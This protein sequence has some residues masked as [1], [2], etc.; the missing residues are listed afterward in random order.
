VTR[1]ALVFASAVALNYLW[2]LAQSPLYVGVDFPA[3]WLH[4]F[5]ASL[6]DGLMV[7]T[8]F[9]IVALLAQSMDWYRRPAAWHYAAMAAAALAIAFAVEWWGLHV[10]K[11][12]QYS[13]LMPLIPGTGMGAVP[14]AQ[15]LALPPLIFSI[16]RR[17]ARS[18]NAPAKGR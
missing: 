14:L 17:L 15:M 18:T 5:I 12:W 8:I 10:A 6:G 13:E 16:A 1:L 11:R 9:G 4:C 2:E 3:A 7:L